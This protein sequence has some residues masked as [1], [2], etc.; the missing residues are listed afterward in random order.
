[1]Q[2]YEIYIQDDRYSVPTLV[3]A[4]LEDRGA[5]KDRAN[6]LLLESPHHISVEVCQ[7]GTVLLTLSEASSC[8]PSGAAADQPV[9]SR[10]PLSLVPANRRPAREHANDPADN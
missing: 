2:T 8:D 7:A 6:D 4:S 10:A 3:F 5:A 9:P 1:M